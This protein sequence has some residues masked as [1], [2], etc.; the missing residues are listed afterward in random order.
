MLEAACHWYALARG[1]GWR[2]AW[3]AMARGRRGSA[4]NSHRV[5]THNFRMFSRVARTIAY[6]DGSLQIDENS[7]G[8]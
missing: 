3:H 4:V 5:V 7:R 8:Y 2:V 1:T 6:N